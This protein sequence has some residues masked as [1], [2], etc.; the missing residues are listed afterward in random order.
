MDTDKH[1]LKP[2]VFIRGLLKIYGIDALAIIE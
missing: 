1:K 2:P